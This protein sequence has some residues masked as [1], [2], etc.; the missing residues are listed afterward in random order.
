VEKLAKCLFILSFIFLCRCPGGADFNGKQRFTDY[1]AYTVEP[2]HVKTGLGFVGST[3]DD[4]GMS[5]KTEAGIIDNLQAGTNV[6]HDALGVVNLNGK[7]LFYKTGN[8]L[9]S[10]QAGIKWF[11]PH[12]FWIIPEEDRKELENVD[13]YML[14]LSITTTYLAAKW[15]TINCKLGYAFSTVRG[16][17]SVEKGLG[18]GGFGGHEVFLEPIA[19][20]Y[21]W[22]GYAF[23]LG[24][25]LPVYSGIYV[26][27]KAEVPIEQGIVA[28]TESKEFRKLDIKDLNTAYFGVQFA[29]GDFNLRI[30]GTKGLRFFDRHLKTTV[31]SFEI[32][33]RF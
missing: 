29:W 28:G 6:A 32:Y 1:T 10:A 13:V 8:F 18:K 9:F 31:P 25:Q 4:L 7:Y 16:S 12:N 23:I 5:I 30:L 17:V 24:W 33:Y 14:P 11:N 2:G 3:Y 19:L 21:L 26:D 15:A 22:D 27:A 20:F